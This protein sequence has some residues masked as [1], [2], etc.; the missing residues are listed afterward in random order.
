VGATY[1]LASRVATVAEL[2]AEAGVTA[3]R[4][5]LRPE[6]WLG[7]MFAYYDRYGFPVGTRTMELLLGRAGLRSA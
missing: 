3:T 1:E 5:D 4:I 2:A 7:A 6:G